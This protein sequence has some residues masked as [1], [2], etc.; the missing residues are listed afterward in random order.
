MSLIQHVT[1][2][3]GVDWEPEAVEDDDSSFLLPLS[4]QISHT[5]L[6]AGSIRNRRTS[7][8]Y[9]PVIA[10]EHEIKKKPPRPAYKVPAGKRLAQ[11]IIGVISCTL[12]S[13]V[14]FGFAA[15]KP[16][17]V[18]RQAYRDL[19][20]EEELK[21]DFVICYKQDLKLNFA[22]TIASITTNIS[23]LF[24]GALLDRYGPRLCGVISSLLLFLGGLCMAFESDLPFD[25][26][27]AGHFLLALGGTFLFVPSFQLSN[28]FPRFQGLVLALITGA[29]DASAAVF[30][31]FRVIYEKT[32]H[33]FSVKQFFL[34]YLTVPVFVFLT[35]ILIMPGKSY[36]NRYE[37]QEDAEKAKDVEQ[38]VHDSDDDLDDSEVWRVRTMR[39]EDRQRVRAEIRT[40]LGNS[41]EQAQ[42][43]QDLAEKRLK[44]QAWGALHGLSAWQQIKTP[45]FFLI[46]LFTILQM[47]RMNLLIATVWTQYRYLLDSIEGA[48]RINNFFDIA[49]PI[50]GVIAVPFIGS[51]LDNLSVAVILGLVVSLSTAIGILGIIPSIW[52]G[53]VNVALFCLLRP[54]YY[55]AMS[56]YAVKVFGL[57]TFGT[58]YGTIVCVSGLFTFGQAALQAVTHDFFHDNPTPVNLIITTLVLVVGAVMVTYVAV[59]GKRVQVEI[60]E[61]EE[62]RSQY[63]TTPQMT[64]RLGPTFAIGSPMLGPTYGTMRSIPGRG[65]TLDRP[66]VANLRMLS[67]VQEERGESFR[68]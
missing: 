43:E 28:A 11:V 67:A 15:L 3:E 6:R 31:V 13:G 25:A 4:R 37:L 40:L 33:H 48:D 34:I 30:L 63:I 22:F 32:R 36:E 51:I 57:A 29:F 62:R 58:I 19:C 46:T 50:A 12:A 24:V 9:D 27:I 2:F 49:L 61:E 8:S 65:G 20:T 60:F 7:I 42:H 59:A 44:S 21:H 64:P 26:I 16:I 52:G 54:L 38:D 23:A 14:V 68:I 55:S 1:A 5:S 39:A 66:S 35:Q 41:E 45:W 18:D 10:P 47:A 17:L 53:Y 56:D